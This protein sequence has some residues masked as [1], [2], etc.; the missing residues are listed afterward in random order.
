[1]PLNFK[2][3]L[4]I[5]NLQDARIKSVVNMW[6]QG[7]HFYTE[8]NFVLYRLKVTPV[9]HVQDKNPT[10]G[11][12]PFHQCSQRCEYERRMNIVL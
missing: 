8:I 3:N 12:S 4:I 5:F 10:G 2:P 1:M 11:W 7:E 6:W 9:R